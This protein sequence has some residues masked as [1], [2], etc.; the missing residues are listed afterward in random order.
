MIQKSALL[1]VDVQEDF[2]SS[3]DLVP[4][5]D[6]LVPAIVRLLDG[7]RR[8]SWPVIHIR[9][10]VSSDGS[11]WMPH[12]RRT[13]KPRCVVGTPGAAPPLSLVACEGEQVIAKR[14]FSGFENGELATLL[15]K[16]GVNHVVLAGVHTH[17]CIRATATDAY[18]HGY[19]VTIASDAVGSYNPEHARHTLGW[20]DGR[21]ATCVPVDAVAGLE[22]P[23][24]AAHTSTWEHRDPCDWSQ[25]LGEVAIC[26]SDVVEK[27]AAKL[28]ERQPKLADMPVSERAR[29]LTAWHRLLNAK[30]QQWIDL[31]VQQVAKPVCDARDEV[32]YGLALLEHVATT[33]V[34]EERLGSHIV[35]YRPHGLVGLITP[36]NNP[37]AIPIGKIAPAIGMGNTALWKPALPATALSQAICVSLAEVGLDPWIG[38]VPGD[39][40]TGRAVASLGAI[41]AVS[42]TGASTAGYELARTCAARLKPLQAELGGNN[43]AI[44]MSVSDLAAVARDLAQAMFSFSGQRCTAIRRL[45]VDRSIA[46]AFRDA[47]V[48]AIEAL[49]IGRPDADT[50]NI[51]PVISKPRQ[52]ILLA[53]IR[54]ATHNNGARVLTGGDAAS[55]GNP[56]GCWIMPTLIDGIAADASL[57]CEE[58]FGPVVVMLEAGNIDEAIGLHNAVAHGLLGAIYSED[59]RQQEKFLSRAQAGLLLVNQARPGFAAQ[60]PF[61]GWKASGYGPP[62]HGRWNREAFARVQAVY[63]HEG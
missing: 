41:S 30:L 39:A 4:D 43:A 1:L 31:L 24:L 26:G 38:M 5:I 21:A 49:R 6:T 32:A 35:R 63:C 13:G 27:L 34:D 56:D 28:V 62:E 58:Q 12:W 48:G 52:Q 18:A 54:A 29:R 10:Q 53:A 55:W 23:A 8:A 40:G 61:F 19:A 9:T 37:F 11:D 44:V 51:G 50:T 20:L 15:Q 59:S 57:V 25:L 22:A 17:A 46:P 3:P 42:F 16:L 36:W 33:L 14:F 47:L 60:G 7:A 45:I 2:L